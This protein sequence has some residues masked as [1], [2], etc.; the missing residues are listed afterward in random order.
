MRKHLA[1]TMLSAG[2]LAL[3]GC[4]TAPTAP[5]LPLPESPAPTPSTINSWNS[6][7][8]GEPSLALYDDGTLGGFDGCNA[9]G[10]S[11]VRVGDTIELELGYGTLKACLGVDMWLRDAHTAQETGETLEVFNADGAAIGILTADG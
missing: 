6:T 9:F 4:A 1:I 8:P 5:P 11:Y 7:E 2:L 3:A 10:G